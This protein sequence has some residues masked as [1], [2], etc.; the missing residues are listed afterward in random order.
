MFASPLLLQLPLTIA[1]LS[2]QPETPK[3]VLDRGLQLQKQDKYDE[4]IALLEA[5]SK[6]KAPDA[7]AAEI[8]VELAETHFR[9]GKDAFEG[10]LKGVRPEPCLVESRRLFSQVTKTYPKV[11]EQS[12][13]A[14]YM[15]GS[16]YILLGDMQRAYEAY[17]TAYFEYKSKKYQ[18]RSLLRIGICLAGI[19]EAKKAIQIFQVFI[20]E[21][22]NSKEEFLKP[23]IMKARKYIYELQLVGKPAKAIKADKWLRGA[24]PGGLEDLRGE[25]VVLIFFATWCKNCGAELVHI[26][27]E[28]ARWSDKGII[29]IG[30]IDPDDPKAREPVDFY[31]KRNKIDFT[32][33]AFDA[34]TVNWHSYR[35]TGL[36]AV[37]IVDKKGTIRWRGHSAFIGH[38]LI[39]KLLAES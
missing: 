33:V 20:K 29:F 11:E 22:S 34:R 27:Q 25:V 36:P 13:I 2:G 39:N 18:P 6:L 24:V 19:G 35:V 37:A 15:V 17:C 1:L 31:V 14:A 38:T 12:A 4:A 3:K 16:C 30:I 7:I 23:L 10:K 32:D 28:I 9:K 26:K 21:Y 8:M 5:G